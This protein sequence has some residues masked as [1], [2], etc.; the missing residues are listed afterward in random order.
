MVADV[1]SVGQRL[2]NPP[3]SVLFLLKRKGVRANLPLR[4]DLH[5]RAA[6]HND[7]LCNGQSLSG[8]MGNPKDSF[9]GKRCLEH[10]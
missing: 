6:H 5:G 1:L 3:Q 9:A 10:L 2:V 4:P 8:V 7:L